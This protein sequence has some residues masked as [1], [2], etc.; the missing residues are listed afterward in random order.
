MKLIRL[1]WCF[2]LFNIRCGDLVSASI[3]NEDCGLIELS[4]SNDGQAR[5][6]QRCVGVCAGDWQC[7]HG[8]KCF[9]RED[10][11]PIPGCSP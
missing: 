2:L 9:Q 6:L 4:G 3:N 1:F 10:G 8:L 7:A 5:N 11:R